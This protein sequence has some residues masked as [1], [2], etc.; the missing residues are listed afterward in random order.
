[1]SVI[2]REKIPADAVGLRLCKIFPGDDLRLCEEVHFTGGRPALDTVLR[3]AAISG[4]V[5]VGP[6]AITGDHFADIM[7]AEGSMVGNVL[8]DAKS[9]R[10]LKDRWMRCKYEESSNV[11]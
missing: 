3:R 11:R 5:E 8:L 2:G 1:M 9:F 10:A 6:A 7:D 4:L